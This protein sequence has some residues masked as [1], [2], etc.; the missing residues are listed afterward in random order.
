MI[1]CLRVI[2]WPSYCTG[3]SDSRY[4]VYPLDSIIFLFSIIVE[5]GYAYIS[6]NC[7]EIFHKVLTE[8]RVWLET[9]TTNTGAVFVQLLEDL[10]E[11]LGNIV[12]FISNVPQLLL[13]QGECWT[14]STQ[15]SDSQISLKG[16]VMK[17]VHFLL[18]I[19]IVLVLA[20]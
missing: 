2:V 1:P 17:I 7:G 10:W 13:S 3:V 11:N 12:S 18:Y 19:H 8:A 20:S 6:N 15:K 16:L 5:A 14:A 9:V 4:S